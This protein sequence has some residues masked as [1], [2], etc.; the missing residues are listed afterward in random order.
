MVPVDV[1]SALVLG[2]I[3]DNGMRKIPHPIPYQGS[4]RR[5]AAAI[6]HY[7]PRPIATLIEPFAGSAAITLAAA[8][9]GLATRHI[10]NDL[11]KPLIDLWSAI[12]DKPGTLSRM[13]EE[14]WKAQLGDR[15]SYYYE[16]R[17]E[18]NRSGN[19]AYF[20]YLLAR[21]VKA[22]VRYNALGK[23]NQS[24]DNRRMGAAPRIMTEHINGASGL[25]GGKTKCLSL[26]YK[27]IVEKAMPD[28]LI[29]MDPPYQGVCGNR[30]PRYLKKVLFDE[31]VETL[32][33]LNKRGI[34]YLVSY[35]GRTGDKAHGRKLPV[36]LRL[37]LVELEAGRSSQATLLGRAEMTVESLYLSP[38]LVE[39]LN[40]HIHNYRGPA[41][42]LTLPGN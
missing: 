14:L 11:N 32:E 13:Y 35:D 16:A 17:D 30:D 33:M 4:K 38:A 34:R 39:H 7:F 6:L 5:L 37:F 36:H 28:D 2:F 3:G 1:N 42:Q 18:F 12:I 15:R 21:C 23:F 41:A 19:P 9:R 8:A 22:S 10:I 31:F 29:Y 20:L 40:P 25:L 27:A 26:D 24:P